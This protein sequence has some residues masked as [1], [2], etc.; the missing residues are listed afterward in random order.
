MGNYCVRVV[1][2]VIIFTKSYNAVS[3]SATCPAGA[4][5]GTTPAFSQLTPVGNSSPS[6][7][8]PVHV[9]R[10]RKESD[11]EADE[12]AKFNSWTVGMKA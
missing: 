1:K 6:P 11:M 3:T 12:V 10:D 2:Q 5:Y 8:Y 4:A 9:S 7:V